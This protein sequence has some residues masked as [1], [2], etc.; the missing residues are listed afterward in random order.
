MT[1]ATRL[2]CS[3]GTLLPNR[4]EARGDFGGAVSATLHPGT[5]YYAFRITIDAQKTT[6]AGACGGCSVPATIVLNEIVLDGN[7]IDRL[8]TPL[9]NTC[10]R[11]QAAGTTPCSA[12]PIRNTTW[13]A[14]K[15]FYR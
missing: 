8:T 14:I 9:S 10:L 11:W 3:G 2:W 4:A 15:S 12:T 13:G 5:E 7:A 1:W 6:G